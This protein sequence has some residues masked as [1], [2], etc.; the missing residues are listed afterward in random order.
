LINNFS[1]YLAL[2]YLQP[3][4]TFVSVI[5]LISVAGVALGVAVLI[6]VI[7]VMAGFHAQIKEL[8][9]GF[10]SHIEVFDRWGTSMMGE[11]KRPPEVEEKPWRDVLKEIKAVPGVTSVSPI[12]RG[13]ILIEAHEAVTPTLMWGLRQEESDRLVMKH[14]KL[15]EEGD[16][17]LSGDNIVLDAG[18]ARAWDVRVGDKV[19]VYAPSNLK[20]IVKTMREIDDKPEAE[21]Q[22]AY[23]QLKSLVL[24]VDL[25][26]TGIFSPPR[27]QDMSD[28][29][30]VLV[31]LHVA[32]ELYGM[33]GGISSLGVELTD[34]YQ[35]GALKRQLVGSTEGG[36]T[37]PESWEARTWIEQHQALFD[38]VQNEMEMMYFVLFII[39][40]VAA[41]CV[42]NTMITVTVQKRREIGIISALGSRVSQVIWVFLSQGMIVGA[43]GS[44]S[45][46]LMG[47]LVVTFR[48]DIRSGIA[49]MT[50]REIF[51][52]EIYGLI[53]IPAK[54]VPYDVG[55][56]CA[57]AF[58]LCT[59]AALVPA[60][61][62]AKTEPAVALRD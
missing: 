12:V 29:S 1:L 45:G 57:G 8:A 17:D 36:G 58:F 26:V 10:D 55:I 32:Q 23:K 43:L 39:V 47:L 21:K 48:N 2:R 27:L 30:I 20:D 61:L 60:F 35:A 62:A 4:R 11:N 25:T 50:G 3:K 51:D 13:M 49:S 37:L 14:E 19:T 34:P 24:P 40:I 52:S 18:L 59:L 56:I 15:K 22:E 7:S 5:T 33:E 44:V 38:T 41:F 42:M 6:V 53:E 54:V 16:F 9:L 46:V 31:P 28:I